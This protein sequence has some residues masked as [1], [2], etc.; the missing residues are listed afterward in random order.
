MDHSCEAPSFQR[1]HSTRY[2]PS[3]WKGTTKPNQHSYNYFLISKWMIEWDMLWFYFSYNTWNLLLRKRSNNLLCVSITSGAKTYNSATYRL[4]PSK[5]HP[6]QEARRVRLHREKETHHEERSVV[7]P[8]G[9]QNTLQNRA[10]MVR[11]LS[12]IKEIVSEVTV[13]WRQRH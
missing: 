12:W 9:L 3:G 7:S 6:F 2:F 4:I 1:H 8:L 5:L 13:R 10:P 11:D